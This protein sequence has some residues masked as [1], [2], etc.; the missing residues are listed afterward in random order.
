MPPRIKEH[1]GEA[2]PKPVRIKRPCLEGVCQLSP[3]TR[4]QA[5]EQERRLEIPS[6]PPGS[7]ARLA[8]TCLMQPAIAWSVL[9]HSALFF[10]ILY[11]ISHPVSSLFLP[12]GE[13]ESQCT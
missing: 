3:H 13:R 10:V 9:H 8:T 11:L 4:E 2:G 7:T 1:Q 6:P 5:K 12:W